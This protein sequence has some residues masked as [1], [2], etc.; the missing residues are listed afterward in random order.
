MDTHSRSIAIDSLKKQLSDLIL[1][2]NYDLLDTEVLQL[3]QQLDDLLVPVFNQQLHFLES[4]H[5]L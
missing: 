2:K 5:S 4:I 3:S 1:T